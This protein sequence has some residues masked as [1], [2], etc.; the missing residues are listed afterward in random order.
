MIA[1][2]LVP[3]ASDA[4][5]E[6]DLALFP[7]TIGPVTGVSVVSASVSRRLEQE[8]NELRVA[9]ILGAENYRKIRWGH[10]GDC[11]CDSIIENLENLIP[12]DK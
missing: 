8:R 10:D 1:E 4:T 12:E 3:Q 9:I 11:G 7:V 5:P 2:T 6:T